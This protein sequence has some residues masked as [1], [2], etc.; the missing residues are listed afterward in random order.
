ME[1]WGKDTF[2]YRFESRV[3]KDINTL[4]LP[5]LAKILSVHSVIDLFY[6]LIVMYNIFQ[7][8]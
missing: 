2:E 6:H 8:N 3:E 4:R 1:K 7:F 5:N